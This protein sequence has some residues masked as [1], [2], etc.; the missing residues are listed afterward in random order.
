MKD[1]QINYEQLGDQA[2]K[3]REELFETLSLSQGLPQNIRKD[4][5]SSVNKLDDFRS[6]A[7]EYM[8][9]QHP[10]KSINVFY[11]KRGAEH[12]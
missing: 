9:K 8:F 2:K 7:E 5:V 6:K 1:T 12:D 11:G 3:T 4:L 10:E